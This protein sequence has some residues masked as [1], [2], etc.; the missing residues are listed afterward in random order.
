MKFKNFYIIGLILSVLLST[1]V[2]FAADDYPTLGEG[3]DLPPGMSAPDDPDEEVD[4]SA[5]VDDGSSSSG[6][7]VIGGSAAEDDD[8]DDE[9][10]AAS[11][12]TTD[13]LTETGPGLAILLIPGLLGGAIFRKKRK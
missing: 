13:T 4:S 9:S 10:S 1:S 5:A 11:D 8:D 6:G 2:A 7:T 3:D 12:P